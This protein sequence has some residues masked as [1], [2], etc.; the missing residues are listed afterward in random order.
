MFIKPTG[1]VGT[2][3]QILHWTLNALDLRGMAFE[4]FY[5]NWMYCGTN[6]TQY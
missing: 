1:I 2:V 4:R 5:K 3:L 6:L